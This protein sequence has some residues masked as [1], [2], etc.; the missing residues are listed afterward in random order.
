[1]ISFCVKNSDWGCR[2][3]VLGRGRAQ[4]QFVSLGGIII[5]RSIFLVIAGTTPAAGRTFTFASMLRKPIRRW[6]FLC[7]SSEIYSES[8]LLLLSFLF[9]SSLRNPFLLIDPLTF[10]DGAFYF[11]GLLSSDWSGWLAWR[12]KTKLFHFGDVS[13]N[14]PKTGDFIE[15][16]TKSKAR[17][18]RQAT[19][20]ITPVPLYWCCFLV[21][22]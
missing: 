17:K 22:S 9:V 11:W 19:C 6:T 10:T 18:G 3:L 1:M 4:S 20:K 8:G 16:S 7:L 5:L 21:W 2:D 12:K 14:W 15:L 13:L